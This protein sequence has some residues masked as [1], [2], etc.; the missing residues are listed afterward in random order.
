MAVLRVPVAPELLTWAVERSGRDFD[1]IAGTAQLKDL[2]LWQDREKS[3][4]YKQL[5][6]FARATYVPLGYFFLSEPPAETVPIPDYRTVG[7]AGV[8]RP[9]PNLLD[10]ISICEQRQAWYRD[11]LRFNEAETLPFVGSAQVGDPVQEVVTAIRQGL[12]FTRAERAS[13]S[14]WSEALRRLIDTAE[15]L[16]IL[17]MVSGIVGN[18]TSRALDRE[19]FRGFALTDGRAPLIFI[20]G[21]DTKAAQIFT[22]V[23]EVA[24]IWLGQSAL[25]DASLDLRSTNST[26]LWCNQ[27]A[28][29]VLVPLADLRR[30]YNGNA[31]INELNRLARVYKVSTLVLLRRIF[32][33]G[34]LEWDDYRARYESELVRVMALLDRGPSSGGDFYN[35]QPLR[36][37]RRLAQAVVADTLAGRTLHRDAYQLLGT[38]KHETFVHL[39]EQVGVA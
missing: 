20:N 1:E 31:D 28:A 30:V 5:E 14:N 33:G 39:G 37:S 26:E 19:E 24:H 23:H 34:F 18:N 8:R 36:V 32:D 7:N 11:Y 38:R 22:L 12:Q 6:K 21:R 16:G 15:E 10:T 13:D 27:V 4:T 17:V 3:P 25:T 2:P 9:S 35:T 29:E